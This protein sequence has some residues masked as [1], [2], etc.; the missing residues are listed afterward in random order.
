MKQSRF[1][2]TQIVRVAKGFQDLPSHG[3]NEAEQIVQH[4]DPH[5]ASLARGQKQDFD[6]MNREKKMDWE[7]INIWTNTLYT[8]VHSI[9]I[10]RRINF[11]NLSTLHESV[12]SASDWIPQTCSFESALLSAPDG[13]KRLI[14]RRDPN[15]HFAAISGQLIKMLVQDLVVILDEMMSELLKDYGERAGVFPQSKIEKLATHLDERYRWAANGCLELVAVRNVLSHN[16][17]YWNKRSIDIVIPFLHKPP[18]IN[19]RLT[20]GFPMLFLYRKAIRTFL[21]ETARDLLE[22]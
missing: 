21:N 8:L 7:R 18:T 6:D 20:I 22:E 3:R 10:A 4:D 1:T 15:K 11:G 16:G 17:G 5:I 2:E 14:F 9:E 19:D 13:G 12:D